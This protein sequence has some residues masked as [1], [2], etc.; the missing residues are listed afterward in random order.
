MSR[1][2]MCALFASVDGV[3]SDPNLW[4]FDAFDADLGRLMTDAI[5]VIDDAILGRHTYEMWAGYWPT[6]SP[7]DDMPFADFINGVPK[8]VA[9][10]T[11]TQ[12]DL[13]WQ[14]SSL[15]GG[16]LLDHVRALKETPGRDIAVQGSISVVR[17]LVT[18]GL[19]DA[20]TLIVHPVV[21]GEGVRLFEGFGTTRLTLLDSGRTTAGNVVATYGPRPA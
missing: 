11:L 2:V 16:N 20:L 17:Q 21:A 3:V 13:A 6:L 18:A 8:H 19:L 7:E 5:D 1:R 12:A 4:Q 9:S 15:I 14:N 10:T